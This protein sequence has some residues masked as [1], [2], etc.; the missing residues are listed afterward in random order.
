MSKLSNICEELKVAIERAYDEGVTVPDA[1][2]LAARTL[3]A[4]LEL[5]DQIKSI[6]LDSKMRKNGVKSIRA[7]V[8]MEEISKHDKKPAEA[9]LDHA[10]NLNELVGIEEKGF[11]EA[12]SERDRLKAYLGVFQD[13]HIYF[14]SIMKGT[15]EG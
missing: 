6:D 11:S 7:A 2:K 12:E 4:R 10:V 14:R 13:A 1:E 3:L 9:F 8:Y 15:Y 5:A